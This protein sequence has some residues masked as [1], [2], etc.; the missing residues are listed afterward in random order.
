MK[1]T[2]LL[3]CWAQAYVSVTRTEA[4][5]KRSTSNGVSCL[6]SSSVLPSALRLR[7]EER[8]EFIASLHERKTEFF[9]AL[10]EKK[11]LPL[12]PGVANN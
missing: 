6:A 8:N 3:P 4:V 9:M 2:Y 12:R 7:C 11:L 1:G 5:S 10:V